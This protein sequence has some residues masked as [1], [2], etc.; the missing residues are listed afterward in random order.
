MKVP[1]PTF[2]PECRLIR[3][4]A[5]RNER[6]FYHRVCEKC[7]KKIISVCLFSSADCRD[8]RYNYISSFLKKLKFDM[9]Y[10]LIL[11]GD[12][13]K[14][15]DDHEEVFDEQFIDLDLRTVCSIISISN[16]Y[17]GVDTGLFHIA[18]ALD[19]P[20]IVFFRNNGCEN[21]QYHNTFFHKSNIK[22]S[23][24]CT[25][26]PC[27]VKCTN[28]VRCMDDF[29]LNYYYKLVKLILN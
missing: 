22:C 29:D 5:R 16:L 28:D 17:L 19:V 15:I 9:G 10:S 6:S 26:T 13:D 7:D 24:Y 8:L 20:Q 21:N 12:L 11:V 25:Y 14:K 18:A 27:V 4:F 23:D 3:R 2:C 1:P